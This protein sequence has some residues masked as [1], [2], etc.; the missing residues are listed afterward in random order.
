[1]IDSRLAR[2]AARSG[3]SGPLPRR[4]RGLRPLRRRVRFAASPSPLP[5]V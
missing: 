4:L 3:A 5:P 2:P 1:M